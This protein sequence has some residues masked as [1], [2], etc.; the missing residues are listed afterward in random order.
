MTDNNGQARSTLTLGP[1]LG[2]NTVTVSVT[3]ILEQQ[4]F[5]AEGIR[6]PKTFEIISGDDQEAVSETALPNPFVVEVR[7]QYDD[8]LPDVEVTFSVTSGGGAL[9]ATSVMTDDN[10]RTESTLT[11]GPDP[12]TNIVEVTVTGI[13]PKLTVEAIAESPP[14][15]QDVNG[16]DVV[17]ILDLVFVASALGDEGQ[18]LVAD[19]N[20]DGVVNILDL[21]SVA[22]A[23]GDVAAAPSSD[24]RA[25]AMLTAA[26]VGEW[27]AQVEELGLMDA[28]AKR[29]VLFLEQLLAVLTP[30]ETVLLPNY[31]NPFNPE[32]WIPYR[33]AEDSNVT[34]TIYDTNGVVV[35][36]LDLGHQLAGHYADRGRAAYWDGRNA[37]GESVASGV[38]F[39]Q[40][41]TPSFR[42]IRRMVILK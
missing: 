32:T 10:G 30:K 27:L 42:Q 6:I 7:D 28:T 11:L 26:D 19:V 13:Q 40:L 41:A 16:D 36:R 20:A 3:R 23:L 35:R 29:G 8:P 17:N 33:L 14:I 31:P 15:P 22:G 25:L 24:P 4:I 1:N 37:R 39:Y 34:L 9:S 18:G 12:G 2:A 21:V 38:Y 5:N